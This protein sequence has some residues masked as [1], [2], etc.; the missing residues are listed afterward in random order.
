MK[1]W[2]LL[3]LLT[4]LHMTVATTVPAYSSYNKVTVNVDLFCS[5]YETTNAIAN[6]IVCASI[7]DVKLQQH[8][9]RGFVYEGPPSQNCTCIRFHCTGIV[10]PALT[11]GAEV[12]VYARKQCSRLGEPGKTMQLS[13]NYIAVVH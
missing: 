4:A 1:T 10:T 11:P 6:N 8:E 13:R 9:C 5:V 7:C 12:Q 3:L 2:D